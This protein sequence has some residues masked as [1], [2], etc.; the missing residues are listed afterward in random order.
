M[1]V[2]TGW[3][4]SGALDRGPPFQSSAACEP[5]W[6]VCQSAAV[7]RS[8]EGGK[9]V[10]LSAVSETICKVQQL[11]GWTSE[12]LALLL[13]LLFSIGWR[14]SSGLL[15]PGSF[16]FLDQEL[17]DGWCLSEVCTVRTSKCLE[18]SGKKCK[19]RLSFGSFC[20]YL[21]LERP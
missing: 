15:I 20:K 21:Y 19:R 12:D 4:S 3:C 13:L 7:R 1:K 8:D 9:A 10:L 16:S 2:T 14:N 11:Q 6:T 5:F 18:P 17:D